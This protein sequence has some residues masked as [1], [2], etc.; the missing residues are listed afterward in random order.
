[1]FVIDVAEGSALSALP[2]ME[3]I[4]ESRPTSFDSLEE[5][6]KWGVMSGQ[7]RKL[8]SARV[9]MPYQVIEKDGKFV[10]RTDLLASK[11][12]WKDWFKGMDKCFLN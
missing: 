2:F 9:S 8:E 3:Q 4:V 7:V 10:W 12:Y 5:V 11:D 6:I 1:L